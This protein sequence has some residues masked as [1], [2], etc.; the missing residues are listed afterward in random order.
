V[1]NRLMNENSPYL[2]QHQDN[3]VDW[4]PWN[5]EALNKAR[6]EDKPIFLSIGYAACHWCHVM[7]HESFED[8]ETAAIMNAHFIN[9]KVDREERPDLDSLYMNAV[10]TITGQG[11]WPMSVFLTPDGKPFYGGTYFPPVRRYNMPAFK[12]V[13]ISLADAWKKERERVYQASKELVDALQQ[14]TFPLNSQDAAL[15][16]GNLP[17]AIERLE[18]SYDWQNG[19]WG[20][21]PKFPQPIAIQFLLT[22]AAY[23][24]KSALDIAIHALTCMARGGMYDVIGG[25]FSRYSTDDSWLVPHFEKMLYD[26]AQLAKTYLQAYLL[27][28]NLDFRRVCEQTIDFV[29]RE[30]TDKEGGFYSSLDAD[31]EGEEGKYYLWTLEEI[32]RVLKDQTK[33]SLFS[34]A[35][36]L[37]PDG[38]FEGRTILQRHLNDED[39]ASQFDLKLPQVHEILEDC[40][41]LLFHTRSQRIRPA[42]DD[43]VLVSWNALMLSTLSEA[44]RYLKR[45]DY[46]DAAK[47]NAD[48]I[49]HAMMQGGRLYRSWRMGQAQH[50]AFL[51]D[52]AGLILGLIALYQSNFQPAYIQKAF[53]LAKRMVE[54]YYDDESGFYDTHLDQQPLFMRPKDLQDNATP[55]GS[56]LAIL[57]LLLMSA[58]YGQGKWR[59]IAESILSSMQSTISRYPTAFSNWLLAFAFAVSPTHEIAILG[60]LENDRSQ[61]LIQEVWQ[62]FRPNVVLAVGN[63]PLPPGSP[64]LLENRSLLGGMPTAY[65]CRNFVCNLPVTDPMEL[66]KQID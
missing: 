59:D 15:D 66:S 58:F 48:F 55:S 11:G 18:Q 23:G 34:A 57:A 3:P 12:D 17:L 19:G 65:V 16:R 9:I 37:S 35:Y 36:R 26:N 56:S 1:P 42:T 20:K 44:G 8:P 50:D 2:L 46:L 64:P 24:N 52:Y 28:G 63:H 45:P 25:G 22:Q 14:Q 54:S 4:Y 6:R 40:H 39:L 33:A 10:V 43:K 47:R 62:K 13:L 51:E 61:I 27:T 30:L 29:L 41:R 38:N 7:A 53:E 60:D 31:S 32:N 21:A 49:L 5:E